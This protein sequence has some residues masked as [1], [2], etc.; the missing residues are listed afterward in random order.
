MNRRLKGKKKR[1]EENEQQKMK[2]T[3]KEKMSRK[4][5]LYATEKWKNLRMKKEQQKRITKI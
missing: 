4:W 2:N 1:K 5:F 3:K